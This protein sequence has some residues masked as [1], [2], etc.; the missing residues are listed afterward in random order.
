MNCCQ[1]PNL[2]I[3]QPKPNLKLVGFDTIITLHHP[4][5]TPPPHHRNSISTTR[6][7]P[8]GL[9]FVMQHHPSILTTTQHNLTLLFSGG[10]S[11]PPTPLTRVNPTKIFFLYKNLFGQLRTTQQNFN[12]TIFWEGGVS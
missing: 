4:P 5:P 12:P 9:K 3:T 7:G 6:N 11:S 2:T 1:N 8:R 10:G